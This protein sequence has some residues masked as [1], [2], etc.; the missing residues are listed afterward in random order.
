MMLRRWTAIVLGGF[1][2]VALLLAAIGIYGV[3]AYAVTQRA[4]EIGVRSRAILP[5]RRA[6]RIDP[7]VAMRGE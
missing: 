6:V 7:V 2:A 1:S 3:Q 5:A 4:R